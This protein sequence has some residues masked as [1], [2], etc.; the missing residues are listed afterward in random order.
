MAQPSEQY[1]RV[2]HHSTEPRLLDQY[3]TQDADD[4]PPVSA[5]LRALGRIPDGVL[6]YSLLG[7][8][9]LVVRFLSSFDLQNKYR[10]LL[11]LRRSEQI[12]PRI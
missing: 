9:R 6:L 3:G 11:M 4:I 2:M 10:S 12:H 5:D 8:R 1:R 7:L